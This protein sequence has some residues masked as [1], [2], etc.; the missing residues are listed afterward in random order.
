MISSKPARALAV[1]VAG[2][3][4]APALYVGGLTACSLVDRCS[5][6]RVTVVDGG[7]EAARLLVVVPAHDEAPVIG[8]T[9][10]SLRSCPY[11]ADR[12]RIL[13]VAD[14]CADETAEVARRAGAEVLVRDEPDRRG[15]GYALE[16]AIRWASDD[17]WFD[18]V[19]VVDAD[20]VVDHAFLAVL[21]GYASRGAAAVQAHYR[22]RNPAESWRTRLMDV[23]FVCQ[24][25]I[26][27]RAR[28]LLGWSAGLRGNGMLWSR[29]TLRRCPYRAF[30]GVEDLEYGIELA[31]HGIVVQYAAE[32][33][34]A[35]DM[36]TSASTAGS[37][38]TRWEGGRDALRTRLGPTLVAE[39]VTGPS[40]VIADMA[41][42]LYCPPL[43]TVAS[44]TVAAAAVAA[45]VR[46][47]T[48]PW[49]LRIAAVAATALLGHVATGIATSSDP[50][51]SAAVAIRAP[52]FAAW[53]AVRRRAGHAAPTDGEWVRTA[54]SASARQD[55]V[56][57]A[58]EV[59][60]AVH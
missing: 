9:V 32:T 47:W 46:R 11:P 33:W 37:Q 20:T 40:A 34:V 36:P 25:D 35:G 45:V 24:H 30:S 53:K 27:G 21:G 29:E 57:A 18:A 50:V 58:Q 43:A 12:V 13:V 49:P 6:R 60:R 23:A 39:A 54:R 28:R 56:S 2:W 5:G 15:K 55:V 44:R 17:G 1:G 3:S 42:D 31:R 7:A 16:L 51:K 38:R 22:V 59:H 14:N 48:G 10:A 41:A 52:W 26:R 19:V 8:A 4:G